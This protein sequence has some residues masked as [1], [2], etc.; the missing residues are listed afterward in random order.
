[1][2]GLIST[3]KEYRRPV[4]RMHLSSNFQDKHKDTHTKI[5]LRKTGVS[6]NYLPLFGVHAN[7]ARLRSS[8]TFLFCIRRALF[9]RSSKD[10]NSSFALV[11][12]LFRALSVCQ[13][14]ACHLVHL[15]KRASAGGLCANH[16]EY[17]KEK[18]P[19]SAER[20]HTKKCARLWNARAHALAFC[21]GIAC[22][23]VVLVGVQSG[24]RAHSF[25]S[26]RAADAMM[27]H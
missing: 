9:G 7:F 10:N 12:L 27:M 15:R 22:C 13:A 20:R 24:A 4:Q 23:R 18:S 1:M 2:S 21:C 11:A 3:G 16:R 25:S 17:V 6:Y 14:H 26:T 8:G 19:S 5:P